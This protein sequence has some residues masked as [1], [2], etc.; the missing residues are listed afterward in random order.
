[1]RRSVAA[2]GILGALFASCT[3]S[4]TTV[5]GSIIEVSGDL[6]QVDSFTVLSDGAAYTFV[7]EEDAK[8]SIPLPHLRDHLRSAEAVEVTFVEAEGIL[9][10]SDVVDA[11]QHP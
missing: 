1:M 6:I 8:F 9:I 2:L 5:T 10:A 7:P 3:G 11:H 4:G